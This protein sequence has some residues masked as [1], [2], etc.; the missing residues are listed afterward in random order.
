MDAEQIP[1]EVRREMKLIPAKTVDEVFANALEE[2]P[3]PH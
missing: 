2:A 3:Q 1:A